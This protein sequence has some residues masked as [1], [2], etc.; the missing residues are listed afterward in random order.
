[1]FKLILVVTKNG[2]SR[3][4][5]HNCQLVNNVGMD[6]R[7]GSDKGAKME[8]HGHLSGSGVP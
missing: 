7:K 8:C 2:S 5:S 6:E 4:Q 1:M 3:H